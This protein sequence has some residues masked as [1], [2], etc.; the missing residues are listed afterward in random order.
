LIVDSS[1][2]PEQVIND[3]VMSSFK[4]AGQRCSALRIM[5]VQEDVA[6]RMLELLEGAMAELTVGN[7]A[8]L[9]TDVGPVIDFAAK[10]EL[11][12]HVEAMRAEGQIIYQ[13]PVDADNCT[14]GSFVA[15]TAANINSINDLKQ[16]YFGPILHVIRYKSKDLDKV[17][18]EINAY[19]YG[20]TLGIHSRI[21]ATSEYINKKARVGN[22]YINRNMIGAAVGVQPFGGQG[23]SGTGPKAGGP[24]YLH[25]FATEQ[26]TTNNTAAVGGNATLLSLG[27]GE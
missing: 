12:A 22:I 24:R 11:E 13:T 9:N 27:D 25:R 21:E 20:L 5:Y 10:E 17:I 16:E 2:L 8:K 26:T 15:P 7:P 3:V 19:G 14:N 1:A 6:D 18:N 23:L 4:S